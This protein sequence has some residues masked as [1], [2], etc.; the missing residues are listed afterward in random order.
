M[1]SSVVVPVPQKKYD[2]EHHAEGRRKNMAMQLSAS[3]DRLMVTACTL[4]NRSPKKNM[5]SAMVS[6]PA[7]WMVEIRPWSVVDV[8]K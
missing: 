7:Y 2:A 6:P 4:L 3:T 8:P 5:M 1:E